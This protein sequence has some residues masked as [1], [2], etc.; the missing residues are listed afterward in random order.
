MMAT[1]STFLRKNNYINYLLLSCTR[2]VF[3]Y[4][5]GSWTQCLAL[6]WQAVHLATYNAFIE[7][8]I[9][10]QH[11]WYLFG[12]FHSMTTKFLIG[13]QMV[14]NSRACWS[15]CFNLGFTFTA[16]WN[17]L[18]VLYTGNLILQ[19][20]LASVAI[21]NL[22]A[23]FYDC[24]PLLYLSPCKTSTTL[25]TLPRCQQLEMSSGHIGP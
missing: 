15:L 24:P 6:I 18:Q 21:W 13:Y 23:T 25:T 3:P 4:G 20:C 8:K 19:H 12:W 1:L 5:T 2:I 7:R 11:I 17:Y 16:S 14:Q 22:G 9:C 10:L